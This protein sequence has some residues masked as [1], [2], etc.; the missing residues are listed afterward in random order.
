[1]HRECSETV[2][3]S[4]RARRKLSVAEPNESAHLARVSMIII[5]VSVSVF[6]CAVKESKAGRTRERGGDKDESPLNPEDDD[7]DVGGEDAEWAA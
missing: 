6:V 2:A 7:D 5:I 4:L 3:L 1:M